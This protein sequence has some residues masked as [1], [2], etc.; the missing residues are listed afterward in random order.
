VMVHAAAATGSRPEG[1]IISSPK[2]WYDAG[3]YNKYVVN[4]GISTYTLLFA[5]EQ[6]PEF[7][8]NQDLNIPES[9]NDLPDILDEAL[10]NLEWL[11][12]MQDEDGGVYHKLTTANFEG[13][14]MPHEATNQRYVVMK[15]TGAT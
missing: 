9:K 2:G 13:M 15:N 11:L 3:D 14:V 4:S 5:Y 12:T 10:W 6:F 1:T 7:F 8:K